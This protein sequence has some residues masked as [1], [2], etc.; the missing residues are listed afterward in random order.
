MDRKA[1]MHKVKKTTGKGWPKRKAN[2][3]GD[4]P[5]KHNH[6]KGFYADR[7]PYNRINSKYSHQHRS[8]KLSQS[9]Q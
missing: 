4:S 7:S 1:R 9:G 5:A 6:C 8:S 3:Q 2:Q